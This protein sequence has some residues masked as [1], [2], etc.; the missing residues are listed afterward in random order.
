MSSKKHSLPQIKTLE[1][2]KYIG[3]IKN[4]SCQF[5]IIAQLWTYTQFCVGSPT[6]K[7]EIE[8]PT[9]AHLL[10]RC[11]YPGKPQLPYLSKSCDLVDISKS[12]TYVGAICTNQHSPSLS[13]DKVCEGFRISNSTATNQRHLEV[14]SCR[15]S[16]PP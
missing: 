7:L 4:G 11:W 5:K 14:A 13:T 2:G 9:S 15:G 10:G 1:E 16:I 12:A 8:P 3:Q 6:G